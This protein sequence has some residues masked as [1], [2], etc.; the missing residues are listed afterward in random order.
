MKSSA[1]PAKGALFRYSFQ[2]SSPFAV[3]SRD[4]YR[5]LTLRWYTKL[6]A[7]NELIYPQRG[8]R[9]VKRGLC[10]GGLFLAA[11]VLAA[12][13]G[14]QAAPTGGKRSEIQSRVRINGAGATFPYPIYA[15]WADKYNE[16]TGVEINYQSIGSG[17]GVQQIKAGTVNF[18]ASD[19]PLTAEELNGAGLIQF[20]MVM[21]GVVPV[22][23]LKGIKAGELKL[24]SGLLADIFLGKVKQWNDPAIAAE[25]K[26]LNLPP[27]AVTVV[28]R[29]DGS[30]TSW[31]FTNYLDKV[32]G[33]WRKNVGFGKAVDWPVGVG[34][35][36]NE[37]VA[38]YVQRIDGAIGYVEYAYA[39]Q[40]KMAHVRLKNRAGRFVEPS[41]RTFQAA[42]ANAD[43]EKAPGY[44]VVL[45]DQPGEDTW[46]ITGASYIIIHKDQKNARLAKAMLGYFDWSYRHGG[47]MAED[48]DYV[49]MPASVAEL[50]R[51]EWRKSVTSGGK[52]VWE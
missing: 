47:K 21:G 39:L 34:G 8:E 33:E 24:S 29:A 25:N 23:N 14:R 2:R 7:W 43:W 36:G 17:G 3:I 35:K 26:G 50:V 48:L 11:V 32:S 10:L 4:L 30:G 28:R 31:I 12:G 5:I 52:P 19:A 1:S 42:A 20:P 49:P 16:L 44:Y 38:A 13:C 15:Q 22:V 18:G 41:T 6:A 40:N 9:E 27:T 51:A 45:T 37:G 46:P